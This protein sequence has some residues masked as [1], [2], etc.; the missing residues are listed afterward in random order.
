MVKKMTW[1]LHMILMILLFSCNDTVTEIN[2]SDIFLVSAGGKSSD[3]LNDMTI[4]KSDNIFITGNLRENKDSIFSFGKLKL[5]AKGFGD[6]FIAKYDNFG[7]IAWGK[8][9]GSEGEEESDAIAVDN[10]GNVYI[11]GY[12]RDSTNF[13]GV[14]LKIDKLRNSSGN[15]NMLDMFLIK[16]NKNGEQIWVKQVSGVGFERPTSIQVDNTGKIYVTGYFFSNI[17]FETNLISNYEYPGF[18]IACYNPDSSVDWAKVYG[19]QSYGSIYPSNMKLN[20]QGDII[21]TGSFE[22]SKQIGSTSLSSFGDQD[23]FVANFSNDGTPKWV[24]N[25]GS[26][27]SE[28]SRGLSIDDKDNIYIGGCFGGY[29]TTSMTIEGVKY[30]SVNGDAFISKLNKMGD[31]QWFKQLNGSGEDYL[32]DL[33]VSNNKIYATGYYENDIFLGDLT[34]TSSTFLQGFIVKY[35]TDGKFEIAN[36]LNSNYTI[37]TKIYTNKSGYTLIGGNFRNSLTIKNNL[38]NSN[39]N[40]DVFIATFNM[41]K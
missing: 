20:S 8:I 32:N 12:F 16:Y 1:L 40:L 15:S 34:L 18:F 36:N 19:G 24:K 37:A 3:Y 21:I 27:L 11:V 22:G 9:V 7:N 2:K 38:I 26:P 25:F 10:S 29:H 4:D 28:N 31:I 13:E 41:Q 33:Y 17:R 5:K 6:G 23:V 39:G 14:K 35:D 30:N